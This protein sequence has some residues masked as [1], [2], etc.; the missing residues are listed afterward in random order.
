MLR[1]VFIIRAEKNDYYHS[2]KETRGTCKNWIC[3][4]SKKANY[5]L[6]EIL[7]LKN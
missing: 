1:N 7:L 6:K 2:K 5:R 3:F 4:F